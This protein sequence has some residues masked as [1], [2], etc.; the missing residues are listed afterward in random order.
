MNNQK[1]LEEKVA[2]YKLVARDALRMELINPRLTNVAD[3]EGNLKS[4]N[5][6][7]TNLEFDVK[8]EN[9]ELSK[10]DTE[11]PNFEKRKVRKEETLKSLATSIEENKKFVTEIEKEIA[12]EKAAIAKIESGE[13]KVSLENL[14]SL[15]DKL[16][17]QDALNQ[18]PNYSTS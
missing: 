18:V 4:A 12:E 11:H 6:K 16:I 13:T 2:A 1:S 17:R 15:V 10:L 3:L 14:N 7:T 5:E 8:V 9:Y